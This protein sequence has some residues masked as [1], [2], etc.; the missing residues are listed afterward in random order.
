MKGEW[1]FVKKEY[2]FIIARIHKNS[3][4]NNRKQPMP[5]RNGIMNFK[6][7]VLRTKSKEYM[8]V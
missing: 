6:I 2:F 5:C 8:E 4:K 1:G 3:A 7:R